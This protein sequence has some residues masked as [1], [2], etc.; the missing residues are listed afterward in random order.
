MR[1]NDCNC[2]ACLA[3]RPATDRQILFFVLFLF[4]VGFLLAFLKN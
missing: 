2:P 1:K 3:S 4:L